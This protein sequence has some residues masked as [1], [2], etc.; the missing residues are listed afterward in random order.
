MYFAVITPQRESK[1]VFEVCQICSLSICPPQGPRV[2]S[3]R[4]PDHGPAE[5]VTLTD[6]P[7]AIH[8][9]SKQGWLLLG[10]HSQLPFITTSH[11][12]STAHTVRD[13]GRPGRPAEPTS[14]RGGTLLSG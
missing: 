6:P 3:A 8:I 5:A 9:S 13:A 7:A 2:V 10:T 11:S 12:V 4:G 14:Q 1:A